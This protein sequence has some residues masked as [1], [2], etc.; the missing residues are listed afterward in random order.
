MSGK[1]PPVQNRTTDLQTAALEARKA[2]LQRQIDDMSK[3]LSAKRQE[4]DLAE[5]ELA[6]I[7]QEKTTLSALGTSSRFADIVQSVSTLPRPPTNEAEKSRE[8]RARA[9]VAQCR[10]QSTAFRMRAGR[11][12]IVRNV[13]RM[14]VLG[15]MGLL[16]LYNQ[17]LAKNPEISEQMHRY[18]VHDTMEL[19]LEILVP[20]TVIFVAWLDSKLDLSRGISQAKAMAEEHHVMATRI[21]SECLR[22]DNL[23]APRVWAEYDHLQKRTKYFA[24]GALLLAEASLGFKKRRGGLYTPP[25]GSPSPNFAS[26]PSG[27]RF[28]HMDTEQG[29]DVLANSARVGA[30]RS[31]SF[32]FANPFMQVASLAGRVFRR[33]NSSDSL[34]GKPRYSD[35][36]RLVDSELQQV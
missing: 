20:L 19:I 5:G 36:D 9:A 8:H 21:E 7:V 22:G 18:V 6:Q 31:V 12:K 28:T 24:P 4:K 3:E 27:S 33:G 11:L 16:P 17:W 15:A 29:N 26:P 30:E 35:R 10:V 1:L 34:T 13:L 32:M 2:D 25:Q 23:D 14:M